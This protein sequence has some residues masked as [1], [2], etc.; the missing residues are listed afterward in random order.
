MRFVEYYNNARD[1]GLARYNIFA[2]WSVPGTSPWNPRKVIRSS[3][4]AANNQTNKEVNEI[5]QLIRTPHTLTYRKINGKPN[6]WRYM[7]TAL[8]H[9]YSWPEDTDSPESP[10]PIAACAE[11]TKYLSRRLADMKAQPG[12]NELHDV[13]AYLCDIAGTRKWQEEDNGESPRLTAFVSAVLRY[14]DL[15]EEFAKILGREVDEIHQLAQTTHTLTHRKIN[16]KP[17]VWRYM[18]TALKHEY[19]W[20]ENTGSP[21]SPSPIAACAEY[22]KYL[23]RRLAD[24]KAQPGQ[25]ELNTLIE[26]CAADHKDRKMDPLIT[27]SMDRK[28]LQT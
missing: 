11:Y 21:E 6:I 10:S 12:Q 9:E 19:S 1:E 26:Q 25:N 20:P 15:L 5:H 3:Q 18:H 17:N 14:Y 2:G 13:M 22:T 8:K 27:R 4:L 28:S 23:S 24:M 7:H 16:E